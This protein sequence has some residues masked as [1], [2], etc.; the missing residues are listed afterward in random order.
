MD[1]LEIQL[2][3]AADVVDHYI[4]VEATRTHKGEDKP[5]M[6]ERIRSW[7]VLVESQPRTCL[8]LGI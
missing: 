1:T 4:L 6:W 2:R 5:L 7:G 3:E 8:G